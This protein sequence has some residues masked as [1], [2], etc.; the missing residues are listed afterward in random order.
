MTNENNP[1]PKRLAGM[2]ETETIRR[3]LDVVMRRDRKAASALP[4]PK[5]ALAI[6]QASAVA[7]VGDNVGETVAQISP[8]PLPEKSITPT[9]ALEPD[10]LV[11][12]NVE[13]ES[14]APE[15]P[16]FEPPVVETQ[17]EPMPVPI[18]ALSFGEL[19]ERI[20]WRNR[21]E[22]VKPLPL[23]GE[24]EPPGYADTIEG[25]LSVFAWDDE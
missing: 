11:M 8:P 17:A 1:N 13:I 16:L 10:Q 23:M 19:L 7:F 18:G 5:P 9:T 25:V 15:T 20:N 3:L 14:S 6:P 21:P 24:L 4:V 2:A 12:P 22:D